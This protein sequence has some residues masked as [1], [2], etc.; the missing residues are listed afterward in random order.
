MH[1]LCWSL[2][3]DRE[4][5]TMVL[6]LLARAYLVFAGCIMPSR[7]VCLLILATWFVTMGRLFY[8]EIWPWLQ[9]DIPPPYT[10]DLIDEARQHTKTVIRWTVYLERDRPFLHPLPYR[11]TVTVALPAGNPALLWGST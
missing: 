8:L 4:S 2:V 11:G 5:A 7:W 9:P 6:V 3:C 10:I 1:R